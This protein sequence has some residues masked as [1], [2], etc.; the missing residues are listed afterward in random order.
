MRNTLRMT[1]AF[2]ITFVPFIA[3]AATA[4]RTFKE[5]AEF[6]VGI[7]DNAT[8]ILFV[9]GIVIYFYG[10]STNILKFGEEGMEKAR[11]Y[12]FWG[13]IVLF[14][15]FS[16][17]GILRILQ[18]TIFGDSYSPATGTSVTPRDQFQAPQFGE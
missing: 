8:A 5:L 11:A 4:P 3:A 1:L 2:G 18:D 6:V 7:L 16:I 9:L 12:F 10:I 13:I 17:W 15:M 14:M